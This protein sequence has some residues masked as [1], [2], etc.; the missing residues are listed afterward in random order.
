MLN[1]ILGMESN[2]Y[3]TDDI[4]VA[5]RISFHYFVISKLSW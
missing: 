2:H 1:N 4:H 5:V 3:M